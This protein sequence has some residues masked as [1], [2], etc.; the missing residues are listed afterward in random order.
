MSR[1][2]EAGLRTGGRGKQDGECAA[3]PKIT[4]DRDPPAVKANQL[5]RYGETQ[6]RPL[7]FH[8]VAVD[9]S[10]SL[11]ELLLLINRYA[12]AVVG[13]RDPDPFVSGVHTYAHL[14]PSVP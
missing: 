1:R 14:S 13:Y 6:P 3:L 8:L 2:R 11:E 7:L 5:L 10:E 12:D 9:L 4:L